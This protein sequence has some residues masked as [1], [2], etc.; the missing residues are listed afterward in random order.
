MVPRDV[1]RQLGQLAF[2]GFDGY[3]IP[4]DLRAIAREFDLG[5]IVLFARNVE[6]PEQVAELSRDAQ[7]LAHELPLWVSV[8]QEGGRVARLKAPFTVWPPMITLGRSGDHALAARFAR[9]LAAELKAVG[10]SLDFTPVLD[11]QTNPRNPVIGDRALAERADDVARLGRSIIATL[12]EQGIAACGK[13]FPG[14]GDTATD[15]HHELPVVEHPPDRLDAVELVPFREAIAAGVAAIMTAHLLVP[16][17]DEERPA[18]LSP[19]IVDGL[20]KTTLGFGG[21]V[22]TDDMGMRAVSARYSLAQGTVRAIAAGCDAVLMCG[23]NHEAQALALEAVLRAMEDGTLP[24]GRVEDALARHRRVK[25]RFLAP[26]HFRPLS[27]TRLREA[28]GRDDHQAVA[29]EMAR[30]A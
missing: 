17:Y 10:I 21:L 13:H 18:T 15:S 4:A 26:A 12:Q 30:Y 2:S 16:A 29:A 1:R 8:D 28:L 23:T 24:V 27:G 19:R 11:V 25:E 6:A 20:L 14:H 22:V 7:T 9:A 3:T 5:G